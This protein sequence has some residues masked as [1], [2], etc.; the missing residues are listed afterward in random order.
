MAPFQRASG[1]ITR[2]RRAGCES[3]LFLCEFFDTCDEF[4]G[5]MFHRPLHNSYHRGKH[6]T[7]TLTIACILTCPRTVGQARA[8]H[9]FFLRHEACVNRHLRFGKE[10]VVLIYSFIPVSVTLRLQKRRVHKISTR[11][12]PF[13]LPAQ[14]IL[15]A[16]SI[17]LPHARSKTHELHAERRQTARNSST[18]GEGVLRAPLHRSECV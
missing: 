16:Q 3:Y 12:R 17:S 1:A 7:K 10:S 15:C 2:L 18:I 9:H 11:L 14:S 5:R 6:L 13:Y 8:C 4:A